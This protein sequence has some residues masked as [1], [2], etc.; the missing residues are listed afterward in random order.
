MSPAAA[1]PAP[2]GRWRMLAFLAALRRD[3]VDVCCVIDGP[4]NGE[5]LLAYVEQVLLPALKPGEVVTI[6]DLGSHKE[7]RVPSSRRR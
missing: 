3:R 7:V 2:H 5:S 1:W 4:I 6:D